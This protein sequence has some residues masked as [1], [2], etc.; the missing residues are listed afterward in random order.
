MSFTVVKKKVFTDRT[1]I[2]K[3]IIQIK[4]NLL[5]LLKIALHNK[6]NPQKERD[7]KIKN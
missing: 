6:T 4:Q 1:E 3:N 2:L 5:Q 7:F